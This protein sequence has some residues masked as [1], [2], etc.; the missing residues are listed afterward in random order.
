MNRG[1]V[2]TLWDYAA[3]NPD[4]LSF[5]EGDAITI[6]RRQDDSETDWWWAQLEDKEGYVPRNL[7]G[8][9]TQCYLCNHWQKQT[10]ND[11]NSQNSMHEQNHC[12]IFAVFVLKENTFSFS[13]TVFIWETHQFTTVL[14]LLTNSKAE[15]VS[16]EDFPKPE[17]LP[18]TALY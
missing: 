16:V 17:Y 8:V 14:N 18:N 4:E 7:L 1:T 12:K 2:Y 11:Q 6:L 10:Y 13:V 9:T 3:Q 15:L 5:K